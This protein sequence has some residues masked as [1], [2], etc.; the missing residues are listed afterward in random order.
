[1]KTSFFAL[2]AML[3]MMSCTPTFNGTLYRIQE[4]GLYG[5][6]D[7]VGNVIIEPQYKYVS[8]FSDG[9]ALV[10]HDVSWS[11]VFG[12]ATNNIEYYYINKKNELVMDTVKVEGIN[13]NFFL[14]EDGY[15]GSYEL[16]D[17]W[18]YKFKDNSLG[19]CDQI[20]DGLS[21]NDGLIVFQDEKTKLWGYKDGHGRIKISPI[22]QYAGQFN[23]ERAAAC[24]SNG[25]SCII[26]VE[27]NCRFMHTSVED[28]MVIF[29]YLY[30]NG[31][32]W[33]YGNNGF[34]LIDK[35]GNVITSYPKTFVVHPFSD[36][37]YALVET[38]ILGFYF[39]SYINTNGDFMTDFD[40]NGELSSMERFD[41]VTEYSEGYASRL[42][43]GEWVF[44]DENFKFLSVSYDSTGMFH[45]GYVKVKNKTAWGYVDKN[46][47]QVIPFRYYECGDFHHGLA[48]FYNRGVEGY[49][50]KSGEVVWSTLRKRK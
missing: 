32:I 23:E 12:K 4:N 30:K 14:G 20:F 37:G 43:Y 27:G 26:D 50:N 29:P 42:V 35:E 45:E 25:V 1:M 19:F 22:Y 47:N 40:G 41:K 21:S 2:L 6:I 17:F 31:L 7:S 39:S 9:L 10:V 36:N 11:L 49:I 16:M 28:E 8:P 44:M 34:Y 46:F 38:S 15:V 3:C 13:F 33:A 18:H 5:F 24:D 48:Y